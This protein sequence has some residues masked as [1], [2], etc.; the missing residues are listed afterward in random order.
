MGA[1]AIAWKSLKELDLGLNSGQ[2]VDALRPF[3][4][5]APDEARYD[6]EMTLRKKRLL[7]RLARRTLSGWTRVSGRTVDKVRDEYDKAWSAGLDRYDISAGPQSFTPWTY[8]GRKI[9]VDAAGSARFR[10]LFLG[11]IIGKLKPASVLEVGCGDGINLALLAGAYPDVSFTGLELTETGHQTSLALQ[12]LPQ[13]PVQLATYA[14]LPQRDPEAFKR[15]AYT[16]GDATKMPFETGSFDLVFTVLAIEQMERVRQAAL[17][18]IAR[19]TNGHLLNL[20]PF[21]DVNSSLWRRLNVA[22]RDYFRGSVE[23][24]RSYGLEPLWATD[25]F[26]QEVFL[27]SALALSKKRA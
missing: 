21:R 2:I 27:G 10:N 26:P 19:V 6:K 14:P 18:E 16:Q 11:A 7:K 4:E 12:K 9:L 13:L 8:Q 1:G 22:S 15:I 3:A 5:L 24:M 20:E 17:A 25:D 23:E